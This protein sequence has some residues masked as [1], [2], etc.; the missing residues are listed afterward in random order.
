[1]PRTLRKASWLKLSILPKVSEIAPY[2]PSEGA[3]HM[4]R[5]LRKAFR[6]KLSIL[7]KGSEIALYKPS[8]GA[9]HMPRTLRKAS[10]LKLSILP[11]GSEIALYKPS[12]GTPHMPRTLR[13]GGVSILPK[14]LPASAT[15]FGRSSKPAPSPSFREAEKSTRPRAEKTQRLIPVHFRS[16]KHVPTRQS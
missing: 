8:E 2:K 1:M 14:G 15:P 3:P 11:K 4:P 10:W 13:K 12:E 6:F 16:R 9:P 7:P 5:T